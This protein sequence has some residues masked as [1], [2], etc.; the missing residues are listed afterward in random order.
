MVVLQ[1]EVHVRR[2]E[3]TM[4]HS[5][6]GLHWGLHRVWWFYTIDR[7][8]SSGDISRDIAGFCR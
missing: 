3:S 6:L 8:S 1:V 4:V 7:K 2:Q 5:S